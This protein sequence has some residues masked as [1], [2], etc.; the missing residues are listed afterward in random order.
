MYY[1]FI[2]STE[3]TEIV[4]ERKV[5]LRRMHLLDKILDH[6]MIHKSH[7]FAEPRSVLYYERDCFENCKANELV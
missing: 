3:I 5:L 4:Q 1:C 6:L 2:N 7:K